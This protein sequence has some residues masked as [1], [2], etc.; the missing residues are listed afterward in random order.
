VSAVAESNVLELNR[1]QL[2]R[3]AATCAIGDMQQRIAELIREGRDRDALLA[4]QDKRIAEQRRELEELKQQLSTLRA[5]LE[6]AGK[7]AR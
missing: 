5:R 6:F 1:L 7:E 4:H 3:D 2:Q